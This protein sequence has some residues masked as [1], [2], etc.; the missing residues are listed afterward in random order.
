MKGL[1]KKDPVVIPTVFSLKDHLITLGLVCGENV[2]IDNE[3]TIDQS[4]CWL[5]K[6]GN[7][8]TIAPKVLIIAHDASTNIFLHKTKVANVTI[9]SRVFIGAGAI[10]LPGISIGD[11]CIIGA[12][13]IVTKDIISGNVVAG[14]P[15][16]VIQTT[17]AFLDRREQ[18]IKE[19]IDFK[20][21]EWTVNHNIGKQKMKKMR[22]MLEKRSGYI[23]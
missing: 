3:A 22:K 15:A 19:S 8:V 2:Y 20:F 17:K 23:S 16:K 1:F 6:I 10:V 18:E 5:I 4:H 7:D 14:N 9:G 21:S 13:S 12:G 11:D